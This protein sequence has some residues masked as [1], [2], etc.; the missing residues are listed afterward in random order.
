MFQDILVPLKGSSIDE[1]ALAHATAMALLSGSRVHLVHV[2]DA[3]DAREFD[4]P[5]D[6]V[7]WH[8]RK[9]EAAAYLDR[10]AAKLRDLGIEA[11]TALFE[12]QPA[13]HIIHY[14]HETNSNLI[15]MSTGTGGRGSVGAVVGQVLWRAFT[16]ALL[17][18]VSSEA[19]HAEVEDAPGA[20]QYRR[21]AVALDCSKRAECVLPA[22]RLFS[23]SPDVA[24]LLAHIVTGPAMPRLTP[25]T[26]EDIELAERLTRR[27]QEEAE[28]YLEDVRGRLADDV[29]THLLSGRSVSPVLHDFVQAQNVDLMI[30]SAHGYT[31]EQRWPYGDVATNF[32]GYSSTPLLLVQDAPR[33]RD[34][35]TQVMVTAEHW[36]G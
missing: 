25:A 10:S 29:E 14:A 20:V 3:K 11:E 33:E 7:E 9:L 21:V 12:G 1:G 26:A 27:N 15:V 36:G 16:S 4:R 28:R 2:L 24:V 8:V 23:T 5:V 13:E 19:S 22:V 6:P 35:R 18:P 31:G 34:R 30:L 32:I 17:V